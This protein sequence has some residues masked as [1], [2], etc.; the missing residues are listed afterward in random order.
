[1]INLIKRAGEALGRFFDR[2]AEYSLAAARC[3]DLHS[4]AKEISEDEATMRALREFAE[5]QQGEFTFTVMVNGALGKRMKDIDRSQA[6]HI[7]TLARRAGLKYRD[8]K[9][10]GR[11]RRLWRI[12]E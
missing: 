6:K 4:A 3:G 9:G 10:S 11:V 2:S 12:G 1:M 7:K 8:V 5:Q